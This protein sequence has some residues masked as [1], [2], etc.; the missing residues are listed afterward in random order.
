MQA[1]WLCRRRREEV[2]LGSASSGEGRLRSRPEDH[3]FVLSHE[4]RR[5]NAQCEVD[6]SRCVVGLMCCFVNGNGS[7]TVQRVNDLGVGVN[8]VPARLSNF[9]GTA[10]WLVFDSAETE[11]RCFDAKRGVVRHHRCCCLLRLAESCS[12]DSVVSFCWVK[13]M[14]H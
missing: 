9:S 2:K 7:V 3:V 5:I 13:P 11:V 10:C 14:L 8:N 6:A 12:D 1:P 4:R